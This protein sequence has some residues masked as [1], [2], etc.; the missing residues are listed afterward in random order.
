MAPNADMQHRYAC[1]KCRS[2]LLAGSI[3]KEE[4]DTAVLESATKLGLANPFAAEYFVDICH[5]GQLSPR[6]AGR[7]Q[8]RRIRKHRDLLAAAHL[9]EVSCNWDDSWIDIDTTTSDDLSV[10]SD[11]DGDES[12]DDYW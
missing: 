10:G 9:E 12:S 11:T 2:K 1:L 4:F 5:V 6:V 8:L 3:S 7:G